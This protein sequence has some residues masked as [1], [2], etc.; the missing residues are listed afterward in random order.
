[1]APARAEV[2]DDTEKD[3]RQKKCF[4]KKYITSWLIYIGEVKATDIHLTY[5]ARQFHQQSQA[6]PKHEVIL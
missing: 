3:M 5:N 2:P 4:L 1:M 6:H